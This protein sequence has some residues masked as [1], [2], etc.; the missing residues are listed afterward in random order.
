MKKIIKMVGIASVLVVIL[1][2]SLASV[3]MAAGPN[4]D[5]GT[6][7]CPN[8][9]CPN[10]CPNPGCTCDGDQLQIRNG[11]QNMQGSA[12]KTQNRACQAE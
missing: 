11:S 9:D 12:L 7:T 4:P 8:P 5:P 6:G 2:V 1:V 10:V 3:A